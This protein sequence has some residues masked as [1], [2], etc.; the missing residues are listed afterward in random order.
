MC[1]GCTTTNFRH[2]YARFISVLGIDASLLYGIV[3][4]HQTSA[5]AGQKECVMK[6]SIN[7][8]FEHEWVGDERRTGICDGAQPPAV[9]RPPVHFA[10]LIL[11][12]RMFY[13]NLFTYFSLRRK[14]RFDEGAE[15]C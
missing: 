8:K 5:C 12:T 7:H 14:S 9:V 15:L 2:R 1:G 10:L 4:L 13:F 6:R 3:L 11:G